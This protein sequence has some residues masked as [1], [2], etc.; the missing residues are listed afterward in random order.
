MTWS[1]NK[2]NECSK[3]PKKKRRKKN[4][5][6]PEPVKLQTCKKD[7][8]AGDA[9]ANDTAGSVQHT[10]DIYLTTDPIWIS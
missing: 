9:V 8:A 6:Q 1:W 4:W 7:A 10:G 2:I 5:K 3:L